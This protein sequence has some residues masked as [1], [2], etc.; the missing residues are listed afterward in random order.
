MS[1]LIKQIYTGFDSMS[2]CVLCFSGLQRMLERCTGLS[3]ALQ[4]VTGALPEKGMSDSDLQ[5]SQRNETVDMMKQLIEKSRVEL[6]TLER[7]EDELFKGKD[8]QFVKMKGLITQ[9]IVRLKTEVNCISEYNEEMSENPDIDNMSSSTMFTS[10]GEIDEA[11][12]VDIMSTLNES[13]NTET[14]RAKLR[15]TLEGMHDQK[16]INIHEDTSEEPETDTIKGPNNVDSKG[17]NCQNCEEMTYINKQSPNLTED[18]TDVVYANKGDLVVQVPQMQ[19][20]RQSAD[21]LQADEK[22]PENDVSGR[23]SES[24]KCFQLGTQFRDTS[25]EHSTPVQDTQSTHIEHHQRNSTCTTVITD[26]ELINDDECKMEEVEQGGDKAIHARYG[27][28]MQAM[29]EKELRRLMEEN[30]G[31]YV[32]YDGKI[33]T[34]GSIKQLKNHNIVRIVDKNDGWRKKE[35]PEEAK[36]RRNNK[37]LR[38]RRIA[39]HV[40][41]SHET[42]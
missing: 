16:G 37:L 23:V 20:V 28:R 15:D 3:G 13:K 34:P 12:F 11:G 19:G 40:H 6:Q 38:K 14:D 10:P 30:S 2:Q 21:M 29:T 22:Q 17:L 42:R 5:E 18:A 1:V 24:R 4:N 41:Q 25:R 35:R 32:V 39:R 7:L 33:I 9:L 27:N 26:D 8:A 31:K 36:Q